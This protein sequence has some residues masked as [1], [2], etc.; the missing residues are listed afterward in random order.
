MRNLLFLLLIFLSL[1][2]TSQDLITFRNGIQLECEIIK[3]DDTNV[4][5]RFTKNNRSIE[6][7][8][9]MHDIRSLQYN[10]KTEVQN[11]N[12]EEN[13]V[14]V[15]DTTRYAREVSQWIN[16][17]TYTPAFGINAKGWSL[18]YRGFQLSSNSNWS[19]PISFVLDF[20]T[21]DDELLYQSGYL[22][23]GMTYYQAGVSPI[24]KLNDFVFLN[25]GCNIIYGSE[26]LIS[27]NY[28]V[29]EST[30]FGLAT[31]QG[32]LIIPKSRFG[33]CLGISIYQKLLTSKVY[34]SDLGIKFDFGI[35]F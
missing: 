26:R 3:T 9:V 11:Q 19:I 15:I 18:H 14:V 2:A 25:L 35:K 22:G 10:Y 5:Y 34:S 30:L 17:V 20:Q 21:L 27:T 7:F 13:K 28:Y 12:S 1:F 16:L 6:T 31:Q 33:I 29:T 23:V 8:S 4:Y 32:L 24:R